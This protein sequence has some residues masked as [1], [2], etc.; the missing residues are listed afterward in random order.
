MIWNSWT[1]IRLAKTK[2]VPRAARRLEELDEVVSALAHA[3]RRQILLVVHFRG[4]EM[5]A[6]DIASRFE[7]AWP[8]VTRHLRVLEDAGLLVQEKRGRTRNYRI[9]PRKLNVV[10]DWLHWFDGDTGGRQKKQ[11]ATV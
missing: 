6:G 4:G 2:P 8:T 3:S 11:R 5:T 7:C 9:D 1:W 10:A